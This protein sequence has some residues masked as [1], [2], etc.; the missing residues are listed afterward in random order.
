MTEQEKKFYERYREP[1]IDDYIQGY[2]GIDPALKVN[3]SE[4]NHELLDNLLG[5]DET[6]HY[7]LTYAQIQ[8]L[9]AYM[10]E[11]Y[12]PAIDDNQVIYCTA[13]EEITPYEIT[14]ID[15]RKE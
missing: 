4:I 14:G 3:A 12:P 10:P 5:G 11:K 6:G 8:K 15:I 1:T 7:H 2:S 9:N 13:S